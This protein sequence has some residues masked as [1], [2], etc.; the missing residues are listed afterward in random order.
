MTQILYECDICKDTGW[1]YIEDKHD[2]RECAC[3][4]VK[5]YKEVLERS[6]ISK[7]YHQI[8]FKNFE[9]E[10]RHALIAAARAKAIEYSKDFKAIRHER[11]NSIAFLASDIKNGQKVGIGAGKTHLSIAIANNLMASSIGVLYMP[12]REAISELKALLTGR[13][14]N[15]EDYKIVINRYKNATVLLIDDLFKGRLSDSDKNIMFEI[16]NYRYL[17][18]S[19][20]IV[21]SEFSQEQLLKYDEAIG[22]RIIE[23]CRDYL[24]EFRL[25]D[26]EVRNGATLNYRLR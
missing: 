24:I 21:S 1:E 23:M 6:G 26:D 22:S 25:T 20:I 3:Q 10:G 9:T 8:G 12:Y 5:R 18:R 4:E 2:I 15:N 7:E 11:I 17:K 13:N 14:E 16:I 19:P